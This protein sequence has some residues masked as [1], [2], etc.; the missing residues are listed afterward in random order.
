MLIKPEKNALLMIAS[1]AIRKKW[2]LILGEDFTPLWEGPR[3]TAPPEGIARCAMCVLVS[4]E[5]YNEVERFVAQKRKK[6]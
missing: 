6:H 2:M 1:M 4:P 3:G 5:E